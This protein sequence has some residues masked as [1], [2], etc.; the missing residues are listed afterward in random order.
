MSTS[1]PVTPISEALSRSFTT[2]LDY[3]QEA[4]ARQKAAERSVM[5]HKHEIISN[6]LKPLF[7][8]SIA[9]H[10][11]TKKYKLTDTVFSLVE[12]TDVFKIKIR[13]NLQFDGRE[14]YEDFSE[15]KITYFDLFLGALRD[16]FKRY[17]ITIEIGKVE[18]PIDYLPV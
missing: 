3:L 12:D 6:I 10:N 4:L 2:E 15:D 11:E 17:D 14:P 13:T 16:R 1:P 9:I 18:I 5:R 7:D 8:E